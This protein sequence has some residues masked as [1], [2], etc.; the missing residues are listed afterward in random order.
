MK[1]QVINAHEDKIIDAIGVLQRNCVCLFDAVKDFHSF[2]DSHPADAHLHDFRVFELAK[3]HV[4]NIEESVVRV[5]ETSYVA[6]ELIATRP[7][8]HEDEDIEGFNPLVHT[9]QEEL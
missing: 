1:E 6:L 5:A 7:A 9:R 8:L 2:N 3:F 4:N